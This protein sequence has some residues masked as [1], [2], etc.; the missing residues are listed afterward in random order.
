[1][2][3]HLLVFSIALAALAGGCELRLDRDDDET[4][5]AIPPDAAT[6]SACG[7]GIVGPGEVCDDGNTD[8][9]DG[10][11]P[12]CDSNERCGNGILDLLQGEQC[13]DGNLVDGDGCS[14][15]C[16]V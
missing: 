1:M 13:D 12:L 11:A 9:G 15:G 4:P 16:A 3:R 14:A 6:P 5:D 10:C 8:G 2:T 7:D